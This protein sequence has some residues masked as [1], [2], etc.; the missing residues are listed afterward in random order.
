MAQLSGEMLSYYDVSLASPELGTTYTIELL[1]AS[2]VV[3]YTVSVGINSHTIAL[4][5]LPTANASYTLR[6]YSTRGGLK[7]MYNQ[8]YVVNVVNAPIPMDAVFSMGT[9]TGPVSCS[10]VS[11][12][13]N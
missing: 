2:D 13:L 12:K 11:L 5:S 10:S 1:D 6:I 9:T 4:T 7:S 3:V 8:D